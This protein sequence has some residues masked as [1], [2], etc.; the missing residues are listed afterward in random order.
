M[1]L[2]KLGFLL[3]I[4]L[5]TSF[6]SPSIATSSSSD[7]ISADYYENLT[8]TAVNFS[9]YFI[10][11]NKTE[12]QWTKISGNLDAIVEQFPSLKIKQ[13]YHLIGYTLPHPTHPGNGLIR[14]MVIADGQSIPS[15][16]G[17]AVWI[18]QTEWNL[19]PD[20][21]CNSDVTGVSDAGQWTCIP[22]LPKGGDEE[23]MKYITG[24][25]STDSYIEATLLQMVL[26]D[27]GQSIWGEDHVLLDDIRWEKIKNTYRCPP[28]TICNKSDKGWY[29]DEEEPGSV[30]LSVIED[31]NSIK[32]CFFTFEDRI[33]YYLVRYEY[34]YQP[35]SYISQITSYALARQ[36]ELIEYY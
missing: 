12:P 35:G 30:N 34:K 4:S 1:I 3:V 31:E 19:I 21:D 5:I 17:K 13:G 36:G 10:E 24:D 25:Q 20:M 2:K 29:W 8:D 9:H 16:L 22:D 27:F 32:V 11:L 26:T 28:G 33:N 15:S 7:F 23:L 14:L 18:K 6:A